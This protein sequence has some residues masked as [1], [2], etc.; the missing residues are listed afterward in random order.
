MTEENVKIF[1]E[2]VERSFKILLLT[3]RNPDGDAMGSILAMQNFLLHLN[4]N[5]RSFCIDKISENFYYLDGVNLIQSNTEILEDNYDL[6]IFVDCADLYMTK[7]EEKIKQTNFKFGTISI[8]HHITNPEFANLNIIIKNASSTS[9]II[10]KIFSQLKFNIDQSIATDLLTGIITDTGNFTNNA[11]TKESIEIASRLLEIGADFSQIL[12]AN[13]YNKT[14]NILKL[15]GIVLKRIVYNK[16]L[17]MVVTTVFERDLK[18]LD[19]DNEASEGISNYLNNLSKEIKF[20]IL[21]KDND[22]GRVKASLRT[23]RED[24]DVSEIS[25][26]FGGGGHKKAAGFEVSGHLEF[27][28]NVWKIVK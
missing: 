21:L 2:K 4:K 6:C 12:R 19:L 9:E 5:V 3:H 1:F 13:V 17:G 8:D 15:W 22:S 28:N 26:A 23:T 25:L 27:K 18:N 20:S 11:T 7:I 24:V 10:Y 16:E 14:I